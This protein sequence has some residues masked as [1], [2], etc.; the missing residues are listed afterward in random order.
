MSLSQNTL[1]KEGHQ[2]R[3]TAGWAA[4]W[5]VQHFHLPSSAPDKTFCFRLSFHLCKRKKKKKK[6]G[7]WFDS[8]IKNQWFASV[9]V[10]TPWSS[11]VKVLATAKHML[12][13][14]DTNPAHPWFEETGYFLS[15]SA[16]QRDTAG[17]SSRNSACH[18]DT[19]HH[20]IHNFSTTTRPSQTF[21][22]S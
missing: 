5:A 7:I 3:A 12:N 17:S 9:C 16:V 15:C 8:N 21:F 13:L 14:R 11:P 20:Q 2:M 4:A 18:P 19:T 6:K 22:H 1:T 10:L